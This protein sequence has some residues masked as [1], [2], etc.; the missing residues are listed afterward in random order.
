[1]VIFSSS[2]LAALP[3]SPA[4]SAVVLDGRPLFEVS[5][6]SQSTA[7]VRANQIALQLQQAVR[8]AEPIQVRVEKRDNFP[9]IILNERYLMTVTA[10]DTVAGITPEQRAVQ[11]VRQLQNTL[12]QAQAERS[13]AYLRQTILIAIAIILLGSIAHRWLGWVVKRCS[14]LAQRLLHDEADPSTLETVKLLEL[15]LKI[16]LAI[17]RTGLWMIIVLYL[18]NLFPFSRRLS[19]QITSFL[20]TSFTSPL[21]TLGGKSYTVIALAIL[22]AMLSGWAI[23]A[24]ALT[25]L[26]RSRILSLAGINRGAQEAIAVLTR[27]TLIAIGTLVIVQIWG[28]DITSLTL[29]AS[30]LGLGIGL[31][32]QNITKNFISGLILVFERPIQVGDFVEVGELKG[33]VERIGGRS[34]EIRTIDRISII[35]PN[36]RFLEMEVINWSHGNPI[37]CLHLPLGVARGS[38]LQK[39]KAALLEVARSHPTVLKK[40][41]PDVLFIG[42][43][44]DTL[45][46]ELLVWTLEPSNQFFLK[47]DLFFH[48][49]EVLMEKE[50]KVPLPQ[51]ELHI[52]PQLQSTLERL[53]AKAEDV[54]PE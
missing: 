23:L 14:Q 49:Y 43:G 42:F 18:A 12:E 47:S 30:G 48:I 19:Y 6:S 36:S 51:R 20:V 34:T 28:L 32:L 29:L 39:V 5:A 21:L 46:F 38:N 33:T 52:S 26:L 25:N 11:W 9:T 45:N 2:W 7:P 40:P 3:Q 10:Q 17:A 13:A 16:V 8:S 44:E 15:V 37:S 24:G 4:K 22:A 35:V 53:A 41:P 27:Y 31:G 1:M 50:I 54:L